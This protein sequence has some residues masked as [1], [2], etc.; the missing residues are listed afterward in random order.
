MNDL[1]NKEGGL[2][3]L[4][5]DRPLPANTMKKQIEHIQE[6]MASVMKENVHYGTIPQTKKHSLWKPGAEK[7]LLTFGISVNIDI[8]DKSTEDAVAYRIKATAIHRQSGLSLGSAYGEASSNEEKYKWVASICNEEYDEK[9]DSKRRIKYK[10]R[11]QSSEVDKIK[12]VKK[13]KEDIANTVLKMAEKRAII[14][15]TLRVT[16]ASDVFDQS[17]HDNSESTNSET[18]DHPKDVSQPKSSLSCAECAT[19]IT[20]K[21][22]TFSEEKFK[23]V[24]CMDCQKKA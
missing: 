22:K 6:L 3:S 19:S 7:L 16:A 2:I 1:P 17:D 13:E 12:Q 21:V 15:I 5:E 20:E 8:E 18:K 24:L 23:R 10:K 14:G 4:Y 9:P 11:Y